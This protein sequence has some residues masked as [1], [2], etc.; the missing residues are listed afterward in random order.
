MPGRDPETGQVETVNLWTAHDGCRELSPMLVQGQNN[1]SAVMD[2]G[3]TLF[4]AILRDGIGRTLNASFLDYRT[5]TFMDIPRDQESYSVGL[6]DP[7]GPFCAKEAGE[8][9]GDP[10][11]ASVANALGYRFK[12]RPITP[13]KIVPAIREKQKG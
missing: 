4:E 7:E 9:A 5:P 2:L 10:L 6:P 13:Q 1:G 3:Q 12:E 8:G 11:T